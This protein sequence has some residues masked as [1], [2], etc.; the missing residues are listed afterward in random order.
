MLKKRKF[1]LALS[2]VLA[3]GTILGACGK[4]EGGSA[5]EGKKM[6]LQLVW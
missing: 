1:G 4:S 3:A 6:D 2:L 5:G